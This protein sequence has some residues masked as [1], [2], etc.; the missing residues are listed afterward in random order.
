M[1]EDTITVNQARDASHILHA[2][3]SNELVMPGATNKAVMQTN[4]SN[5]T[6]HTEK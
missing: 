2:S 6:I 4:A 3:K 1:L 5:N